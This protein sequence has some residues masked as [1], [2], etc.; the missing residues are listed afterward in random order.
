MNFDGRRAAIHTRLK[1]I[2][3][4]RL[5]IRAFADNQPN[6]PQLPSGVFACYSLR[7]FRSLVGAAVRRLQAVKSTKF[8]LNIC[9]ENVTVRTR[10][11]RRT[12]RRITFISLIATVNIIRAAVIMM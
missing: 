12:R 5:S 7:R 10:F 3:T 1:N 2:Y 6:T 8:A 11:S 4:V 9:R